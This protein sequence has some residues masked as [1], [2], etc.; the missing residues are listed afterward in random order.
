MTSD[1]SESMY[2]NTS[3]NPEPWG[4]TSRSRTTCSQSISCKALISRRAVLGMPSSNLLSATYIQTQPEQCHNIAV[5]MV[6]LS[7]SEF[8]AKKLKILC[9]VSVNSAQILRTFWS[10]F[11]HFKLS[12]ALLYHF[13]CRFVLCAFL[14]F[15]TFWCCF[16]QVASSINVVFSGAN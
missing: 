14:F 1:R 6:K 5:R 13:V 7:L 2:S 11:F 12:V 10:Q 9:T 15:F 8:A 4:N 3:T 16:L